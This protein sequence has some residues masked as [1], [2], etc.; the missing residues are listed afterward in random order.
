MRCARCARCRS[1]R[2][3]AE[4]D[5]H[6]RSAASS[7]AARAAASR[8][9]IVGTPKNSVA[10][11]A[12]IASSTASASNAG[13]QHGR[14]AGEQRAV[15]ADAEAVHVEQ[16]QAQHQA[17][18]GRP[19]PRRAAAPRRW[20]A[21]CRGR[22]ARPWARPVVPDVYGE[23]RGIVGTRRGRAD[24]VRRSGRSGGSERSGRSGLEGDRHHVTLGSTSTIHPRISGS[25]M[26]AIVGQASATMPATSR[27]ALAGL[28]G[29]A[30][31]PAR[32]TAT[33]ATT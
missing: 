25:S 16:R 11:S 3:G 1:A 26:T 21:G 27:L 13:V 8:A 18:V 12:A 15:Q 23:Q 32:S 6:S 30:T 17:V 28:T 22:A 19:A 2:S 4:P 31:S 20:R 5:T 9:Y 33:W 29:T 24:L 14:R 7:S 10:P